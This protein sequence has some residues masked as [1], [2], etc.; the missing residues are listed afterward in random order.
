MQHLR[1]LTA[2]PDQLYPFLKEFFLREGFPSGSAH[3][4]HFTWLDKNFISTF[5]CQQI[6]YRKKTETLEMCFTKYST[7]VYSF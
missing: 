7:N 4:R 5:S 3:M 2:S 1:I 6:I